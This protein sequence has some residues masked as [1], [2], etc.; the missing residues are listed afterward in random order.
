MSNSISRFVGVDEEDVLLPPLLLWFSA[1]AIQWAKDC[2]MYPG[3][4]INPIL[5]FGCSSCCCWSLSSAS[6]GS[7][8]ISP[9]CL[10]LCCLTMVAGTWRKHSRWRWVVGFISPLESSR[11]GMHSFR[12][13]DRNCDSISLMLMLFLS[14]VLLNLCCWLLFADCASFSSCLACANEDDSGVEMDNWS[15]CISMDLAR[16]CGCCC[17]SISCCR[18]CCMILNRGWLLWISNDPPPSILL[19]SPLLVD[20][21]TMANH[22]MQCMPIKTRTII[23]AVILFLLHMRRVTLVLVPLLGRLL[24]DTILLCTVLVLQPT[25]DA[26]SNNCLRWRFYIW[27]WNS[28]DSH[29]RPVMHLLCWWVVQQRRRW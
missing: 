21:T 10:S 28:S 16:W 6:D 1:S 23:A 9:F 12:T 24:I 7:P 8:P 11:P 13:L 27:S 25:P 19:T 15:S 22:D 26:I 29:F 4:N 5:G 17:F 14:F 3:G 18:F 20:T 2:P